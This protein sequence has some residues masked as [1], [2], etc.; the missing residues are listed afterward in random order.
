[1]GGCRGKPH[2][3]Q[4]RSTAD[5]DAIGLPV[6]AHFTEESKH[7]GDDAWVVLARFP[8]VQH[9]WVAHEACTC[10]VRGKVV[11]YLRAIPG[12]REFNPRIDNYQHPMPA[13][14]FLAQQN[15][16]EQRIFRVKRALSKVNRVVESY[17]EANVFTRVQRTIHQSV[18][19]V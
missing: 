7:V 6:Q 13:R 3:V 1:M 2:R 11:L 8:A 4:Q 14:R 19:I 9:Q 12:R 18:A 17:L 10:A 5:N 15:L 16:R